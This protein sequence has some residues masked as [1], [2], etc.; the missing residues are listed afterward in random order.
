MSDLL[1][2][3][4]GV[5]L[6]VLFNLH[7]EIILR[8][9]EQL[10]GLKIGEKI[11]IIFFYADDIVLLAGNEKF[12]QKTLDVVRIMNFSGYLCM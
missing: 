4:Q 7:K 10:P 12:V 9:V 3:K 6:P 2:I 11:S 8:H 5:L 1:E